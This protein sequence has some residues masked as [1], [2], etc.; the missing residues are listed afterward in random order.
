MDHYGDKLESG[1]GSRADASTEP[2]LDATVG[3]TETRVEFLTAG[4]Q[5][6]FDINCKS[7]IDKAIVKRESETW[8]K[9]ILVR[10]HLT[11]LE[12][13]KAK[14]KEFTIEWSV[15]SSE[16]HGTRRSLISGKRE[17]EI[18]KDSPYFT[19]ARIV[20]DKREVPLR[21]G[22]F[23]IPLPEKFFEGNPQEITLEWIDFFRN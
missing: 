15:S 3:R 11:G 5:A 12:S 17:A 6:I 7:G 16:D 9:E 8:P 1:Q 21:D 14:R 22:Y 19:E 23:E 20:G 10:L 2:A 4:D 18:T 13:F